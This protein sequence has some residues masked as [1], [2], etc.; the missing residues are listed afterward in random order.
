M[1]ADECSTLQYILTYPPDSRHKT[2]N[3]TAHWSD[4][5]INPPYHPSTRQHP[6]DKSRRTSISAEAIALHSSLQKQ[7][8]SVNQGLADTIDHHHPSASLTSAVWACCSQEHHSSAKPLPLDYL[9]NFPSP[10]KANHSDCNLA[11]R[12]RT[13]PGTRKLRYY[14]QEEGFYTGRSHTGNPSS[15]KFRAKRQLRSWSLDRARDASYSTTRPVDLVVR[16]ASHPLT[17]KED[18]FIHNS[19]VLFGMIS[20]T[21]SKF[22][23][24]KL[25]ST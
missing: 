5:Y 12:A 24:N 14:T 13:A 19:A 18:P 23:R 9:P 2:P 8:Y 10:P 16:L 7:D 3:A 11:R 15:H 6:L 21:E 1:S 20:L 4:Y 22:E 25:I 17:L